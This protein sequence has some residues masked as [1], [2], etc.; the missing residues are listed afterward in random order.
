[1]PQTTAAPKPYA[2]SHPRI[3]GL[4]MS[5]G[6][7]R[8][9][10]SR[11]TVLG[12]GTVS[13]SRVVFYAT[14]D[15]QRG[16]SGS[17]GRSSCAAGRAGRPLPPTPRPMPRPTLPLTRLRGTP[18]CAAAARPARSEERRVGKECRSRWSAYHKKKKKK[19]QQNMKIV[20][21]KRKKKRHRI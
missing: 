20:C 1:M 14:Q 12:Y 10:V 6:R 5:T 13:Y 4:P 9:T 8:G 19:N 3:R 16:A 21:K 15:E 17:P 11:V 18:S 2:C 7:S